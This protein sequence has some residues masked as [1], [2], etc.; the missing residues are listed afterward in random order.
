MAAFTLGGVRDLP[1][2]RGFEAGLGADVTFYA[3]PDIL[4]TTHGSRP[5]SFQVF[6]RVRPPVGPMGRMWNMRMSAPMRH[7]MSHE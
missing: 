4:K 1:G 6:C 5:V 2:W 7:A 3:V